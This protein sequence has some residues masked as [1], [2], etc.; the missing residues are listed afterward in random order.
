M[1]SV[2]LFGVVA[3]SPAM[4]DSTVSQSVYNN[5]QAQALEQQI[6]NEVNA[7]ELSQAQQD[8][9]TLE[10]M[11]N[12]TPPTDEA[13]ILSGLQSALGYS[14][15]EEE[16]P[17]VSTLLGAIQTLENSNSTST[18]TTPTTTPTE[19]TTQPTNQWWTNQQ[20]TTQDNG[21]NSS[22]YQGYMPQDIQQDDPILQ[23]S[24]AQNLLHNHLQKVAIP[25]GGSGNT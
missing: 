23:Q 10:T 5:S 1:V 7:G 25:T 21:S 20:P 3:I 8:L 17:A 16:W 2:A 18:T 13:D 4:A 15:Q 6:V 24:W 22:T 14:L 9:Q 11:A 19:S 12:Y